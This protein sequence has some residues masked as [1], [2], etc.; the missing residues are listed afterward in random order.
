MPVIVETLVI[1]RRTTYTVI[2]RIRSGMES[3]VGYTPK[4]TVKTNLNDPA[5]KFTLTGE[6]DGL[7]M[8]FEIPL[9]KTDIKPGVYPCDVVLE[10][11]EG[12][13][14]TERIPVKKTEIKIELWPSS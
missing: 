14:V 7:D 11:T 3:L 10:K 5:A 2:F 8:E 4:M 12:E 1:P 13:V 6:V 9:S